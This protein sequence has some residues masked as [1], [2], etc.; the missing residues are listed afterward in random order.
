MK[1]NLTQWNSA[2]GDGALATA[3]MLS[4]FPNCNYL[5]LDGSAISCENAWR[6]CPK[7]R[8]GRLRVS[9]FDLADARW[10]ALL[11]PHSAASSHPSSSIIWT[12]I[13]P[14]RDLFSKVASRLEPGGAFIIVDLVEPASPHAR[15]PT[16]DSGMRES[17]PAIEQS[18]EGTEPYEIFREHPME[19]LRRPGP[20]PLRPTLPPPR[21]A[22]LASRVGLQQS[23]LLLDVSQATQSSADTNDINYI[24][25]QLDS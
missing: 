17:A 6:L 5:A 16:S 23:G 21:P 12:A 25:P 1:R 24:Q 19:F 9:D 13:K 3:V 22:K 10:P 18:G 11:P 20:R 7:S 4:F 2:Q 8:A 15:T 14:K